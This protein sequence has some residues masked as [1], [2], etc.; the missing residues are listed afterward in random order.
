MAKRSALHGVEIE[1]EEHGGGGRALVLVHGFTGSRRDFAPRVPALAA[2]GR[3]VLLDLRG[4]GGSTRG[5]ARRY[6]LEQLALDLVAF[7]D[8][9]GLAGCDL[10]GHSMGGMAALRAALVAPDRIGSL[11]L[12]GTTPRA[13][14][15][16]RERF[17]LARRVVEAAGLEGLLELLR[18]RPPDDP[19]RTAADRRL[20]AAWGEGYWRD[21]RIPNYGAM[22]PAAYGA[23]GEAMFEQQ[24]LGERLAAIRAP[25]LVL[26]GAEDHEFLAAAD[27]LA[28][29]IP[30]ARRVTIAGAGHQPQLEAPEAWLEAIR[31]HLA[32]VRA[33]RGIAGS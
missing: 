20:E 8:A 25:T 12:M 18:R 9:H 29:G 30:G 22:D 32:Q 2:L 4:H 27:E 19:G 14:A 26:V 17:A 7:L 28:A 5:D 1:W 13:L 6:T 31:A 15:L 16:P 10:L 24:P 23:L 21:W 3:T 11:I 33:P